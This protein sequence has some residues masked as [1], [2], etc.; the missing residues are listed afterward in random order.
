MEGYKKHSLIW[1]P[2][3]RPTNNELGK[4]ATNYEVPKEGEM[5]SFRLFFRKMRR[6]RLFEIKMGILS[7]RFDQYGSFAKL[8][9]WWLF[10]RTINTCFRYF[11]TVFMRPN[12][13]FSITLKVMILF[14][15]D[16]YRIFTSDRLWIEVCQN[17]VYSKIDI[18]MTT[19]NKKPL[20]S[21]IPNFAR[22]T[23]ATENPTP[24]PLSVVF[25]K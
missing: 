20:K 14:L 7:S 21:I 17:V 10:L 19:I 15:S 3:Q 22:Y 4:P 25:S 1:V 23:P 13:C 8:L 16:R 9:G 6:E 11:D 18:T 12:R 24:G 2:M 5:L